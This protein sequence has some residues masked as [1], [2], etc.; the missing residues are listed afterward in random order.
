MGQNL[1]SDSELGIFT[2][3]PWDRAGVACFLRVGITN[4][5]V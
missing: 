1:M 3:R 5:P 4:V 2:C